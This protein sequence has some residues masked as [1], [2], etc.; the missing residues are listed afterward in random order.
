MKN[1]LAALC[2]ALAVS[3][4]GQLKAQTSTDEVVTDSSAVE[5]VKYQQMN[6]LGLLDDT[7]SELIRKCLN[8]LTESIADDDKEKVYNLKEYALTLE[9]SVYLPLMPRDMWLIDLYLN[10]FNDFLNDIVALDSA[11]EAELAPKII[12]RS[13]LYYVLH[14]KVSEN[15]DAIKQAAHADANLAETD[16]DFINVFLKQLETTPNN[17]M[18]I[19]NYESAQFLEKHPDSQYNNYVKRNLTYKYVKDTDGFQLDYAIGG[20]VNFLSGGITDWFDMGK[21]SIQMGLRFGAKRWEISWQF[22]AMF[23]NTPKKDITFSNG[24]VWGK[25]EE[26]NALSN[27]F[28]LGRQIPLN[29]KWTVIPRI[30]F[31]YI[32]FNAPYDHNNKNNSLNEQKLISFMPTIGAEISYDKFFFESNM[33]CFWGPALRL[34]FQPIKTEIEGK[35]VYGATTTLSFVVKFGICEEKRVY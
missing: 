11:R 16:K 30:G 12:F 34:N 3:A 1:K 20:G 26:W 2:I 8:H 32:I 29:E 14:G 17:H 31:S 19:M 13:N 25:G 28:C 35:T 10:R 4:F 23:E 9:D 15:L 24:A 5:S 21:G 27:Q 33:P 7:R 22:V 6:R 18:D